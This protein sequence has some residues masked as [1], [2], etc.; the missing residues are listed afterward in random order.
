MIGVVE[1]NVGVYGASLESY[2]KMEMLG[3][4]SAS[5]SR[6]SDNLS[7]FYFVS[8]FHEVFRLVAVACRKT[9]SVAYY[10]VI[11]VSEIRPGLCYDAV[12]CRQHIVVG[13]GL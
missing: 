11:A 6:K 12:E 8:F 1:E 3:G 13:F 7:G 2:L 4:G 9:V 10:D 5:A